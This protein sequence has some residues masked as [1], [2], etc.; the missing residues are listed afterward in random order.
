MSPLRGF[1]IT[2]LPASLVLGLAFGARAA[3]CG[4]PDVDATFPPSNATSVCHPG[5]SRRAAVGGAAK[6]RK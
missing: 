2:V 4:R 5:P 1:A 3:P 6:R